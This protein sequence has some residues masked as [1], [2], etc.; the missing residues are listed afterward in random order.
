MDLIDLHVHSNAS[1]GTLSPAQVVSLAVSKKLSAIALTDHDTVDGVPEALEAAMG[2]GLK[3]VPGTELSCMCHGKEIHMLGLC[4][5]L[6]SEEFN[7]ALAVQREAR[8]QRN[9]EMIRRF[10]EGGMT[11]TMEDLTKES[12]GTVITRAH[13]ARVLMQK[14]YVTSLNQAFQKYLD[15]GKK[16]FIPKEAFEPAEAIRLI[17]TAG[18]FPALAHPLQYK[19]G[20]K[21]TEKLICDLKEMGLMGVEVYYSSHCASESVRLREIC[22]ACGLLPTGGSDFHGANKPD[23]D[24]G[25]GRGGLRVPALLLKDIQEALFHVD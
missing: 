1:D 2:T 16:Y 12:P 4:L 14:G 6:D 11:F 25:S 22:S 17:R 13:F 24:L 8:K 19:L 21:N 7:D 23:I 15:Q 10:A 9:L 5:K 18:G 20:W 3:V